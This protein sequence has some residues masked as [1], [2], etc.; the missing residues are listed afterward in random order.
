MRVA[1]YITADLFMQRERKSRNRLRSQTPITRSAAT[2][3]ENVINVYSVNN[4]CNCP[5]ADLVFFQPA[6]VV[7]LDDIELVHF[8]RVQFHIKNFD[9]AI[10]FKDYKRKAEIINSIP[11]ASLDPIREWLKYLAPRAS[12]LSFVSFLHDL[13]ARVPGR[14]FLNYF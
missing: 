13:C 10:I 4:F 12:F 14:G 7:S 5:I 11:M 6:F 8:E 1:E 2:Q 9:M 3:V